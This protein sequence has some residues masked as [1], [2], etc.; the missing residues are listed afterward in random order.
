MYS[1]N[2]GKGET[3]PKWEKIKGNRK[4]IRSKK[5]AS[6]DIVTMHGPFTYKNYECLPSASWCLS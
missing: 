3:P 6:M 4:K 2:F 5:K 1:Y